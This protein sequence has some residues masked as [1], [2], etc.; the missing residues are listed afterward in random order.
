MKELTISQAEALRAVRE[1][2]AL[3]I[4]ATDAAKIMGVD[5][6]TLRSAAKAGTLAF[7]VDVLGSR[8]LIPRITFLRHLGF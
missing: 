5:P 2:D 1:T 3:L 6:Q 7:P 8:I 4:E